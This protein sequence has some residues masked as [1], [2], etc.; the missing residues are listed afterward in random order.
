M[1]KLA[2]VIWLISWPLLILVSYQVIR[3]TLRIF[4]SNLS[5]CQTT[6]K[7]QDSVS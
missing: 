4:H 5:K 3:I 7:E 1:E 6:P 2:S